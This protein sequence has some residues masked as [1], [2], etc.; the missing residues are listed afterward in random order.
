MNNQISK[1]LFPLLVGI[2]LTFVLGI[3]FGRMSQR[4]VYSIETQNKP[5]MHTFEEPPAEQDTERI[6]LNTADV[7]QLIQL[8]GIGEVTAQRIIDYRTCCGGFIHVEQLLEV[9]GIG[10]GKLAQISAFITVEGTDE[11][12]GR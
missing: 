1:W 9:E 5:Q 8:P 10:E 12:T 7:Q 4:G 11:D 3:F 2:V 6:D